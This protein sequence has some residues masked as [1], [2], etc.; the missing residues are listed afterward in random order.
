MIQTLKVS[1][2]GI[3]ETAETLRFISIG[4]TILK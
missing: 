2:S 3:S 4:Y 1:L